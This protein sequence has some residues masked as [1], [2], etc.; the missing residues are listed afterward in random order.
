MVLTSTRSVSSLQARNLR[1]VLS[2]I[3]LVVEV[4]KSLPLQLY[5]ECP[6][7]SSVADVVVL[8]S[9]SARE[10]SPWSGSPLVSKTFGEEYYM[11]KEN[12]QKTYV[13]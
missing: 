7:I 6:T 1:K 13:L 10:S 4:D 12:V 3:G 9:T 8:D 5:V 2:R 11:G